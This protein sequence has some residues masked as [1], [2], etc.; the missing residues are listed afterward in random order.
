MFQAM[1]ISSMSRTEEDGFQ[2][3]FGLVCKI[4][5]YIYIYIYI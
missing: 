1:L 3:I 4:I 5:Y 2:I